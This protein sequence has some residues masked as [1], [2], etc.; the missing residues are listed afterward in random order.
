MHLQYRALRLDH[1]F[2][3]LAQGT[4][5][6]SPGLLWG[7]SSPGV[8]LPDRQGSQL[9]PYVL[10]YYKSPLLLMMVADDYPTPPVPRVTITHSRQVIPVPTILWGARLMH[11]P[12]LPY[13]GLGSELKYQKSLADSGHTR[14]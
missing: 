11:T 3:T 7:G 8:T 12:N 10:Y 2:I 1:G 9:N 13:Y 14:P 5:I 6:C 4:P